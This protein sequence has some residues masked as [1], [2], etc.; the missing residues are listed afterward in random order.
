MKRLRPI[1][2]LWCLVSAS[3]AFQNAGLSIKAGIRQRETG[4][5]SL[6]VIGQPEVNGNVGTGENHVLVSKFAADIS[7]LAEMRP[8]FPSADIS[9]IEIFISAGSSYT[10]LWTH[11]TWKRHATPPHVRY[12]RHVWRWSA[13]TTARRVLPAVLIAVAWATVV[14]L[15]ATFWPHFGNVVVSK[16]TGA[17]AAASAL[18]APLALLLTLRANSSM[19]RLLEARKAWGRVVLH[20]SALANIVQ[21]SLAQKVAYC[22]PRFF[23]SD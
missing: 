17:S 21:V 23:R 13:S 7:K 4:L 11:E 10:K 19:E 20:S 9:A 15:A 12:F 2:G 6:R 22:I 3:A 18:S 16:Q 8:P 1:W 14:S 5:R